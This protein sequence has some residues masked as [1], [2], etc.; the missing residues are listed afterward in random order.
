M[1]CEAGKRKEEGKTSMRNR[2]QS[3]VGR[4]GGGGGG[5]AE[6]ELAPDDDG[7]LDGLRG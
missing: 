4:G 6:G 7:N 1:R 3:G 5:G 2:K